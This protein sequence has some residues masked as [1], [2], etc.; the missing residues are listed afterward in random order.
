MSGPPNQALDRI[1]RIRW[2]S[3]F[4]DLPLRLNVSERPV[5]LLANSFAVAQF[6]SL[7]RMSTTPHNPSEDRLDAWY[8]GSAICI[9]AV[10]SQGDPLD[11]G[12]HEV[13]AFIQKL[14][15]CLRESRKGED[16]VR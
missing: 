14:N 6:G 3:E 7:G 5:P 9:I 15:A 11:L 16:Q 12:D 10:G 2:I 13:E 4:V 1:D 8:D